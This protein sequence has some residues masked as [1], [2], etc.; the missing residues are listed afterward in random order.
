MARRPAA[1]KSAASIRAAL[2]VVPP[3]RLHLSLNCGMW[4]LPRPVA[5]AKLR[6][7]A[8]APTLIVAL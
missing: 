6:A 1:L 7:P 4:H 8:A 3:A 2:E 5:L